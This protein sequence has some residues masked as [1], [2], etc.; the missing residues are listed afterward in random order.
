VGYLDVIIR[1]DFSARYLWEGDSVDHHQPTVRLGLYEGPVSGV[2]LYDGELPGSDNSRKFRVD[3][4]DYRLPILSPEHI[5]YVLSL[6]RPTADMPLDHNIECRLAITHAILSPFFSEMTIPFLEEN[7]SI[8][9]TD[10]IWRLVF[11]K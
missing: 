11:P 3:G 1:H 5:Q 6:E 10:A 4:S 9:D 8:P 7:L 2:H